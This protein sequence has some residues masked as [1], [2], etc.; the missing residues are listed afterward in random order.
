[1]NID[2][3]SNNGL[4]DLIDD[5][6]VVYQENDFESVVSRLIVHITYSMEYSGYFI[7]I[8]DLKG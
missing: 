2:N 3:D 7:L 5:L 1:V 6:E 4:A 8:Y